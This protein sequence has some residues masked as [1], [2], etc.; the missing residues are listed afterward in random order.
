M[1]LV[2]DRI[3]TLVVDDSPLALERICSYL[4]TEPALQ[5]VGT[6]ADGVEALKCAEQLH[7]DLVLLD[8]Q[9]PGMNGLEV[10]ARL[11]ASVC[12]PL[13]VIV[14]GF[15]TPGIGQRLLA[16]GVAGLVSKQRLSE[17]LPK[18]L[19]QILPSLRS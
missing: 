10:A 11:S 15:E 18:L 7:P 17:E 19:D 14:T 6:A 13:V 12:G 3:R 2:T 5:V 8:L 9:M 16:C 4:D 1:P